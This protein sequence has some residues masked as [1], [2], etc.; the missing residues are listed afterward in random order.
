MEVSNE[1]LAYL[2]KLE[3]E[4]EI[5][6]MKEKLPHKFVPLYKWQRKFLESTNRFNFVTA[7]NQ[8]GKSS[9]S[10][11]KSITWATET[12]LWPKLWP[13]KI[14]QGR[15]ITCFF[16]LYEDLNMATREFNEKWIKEWLPRGDMKNDPKYGWKAQYLHKKIHSL[17][18]NSGVT[19]YFL[20]YSQDVMSM[21]AATVFAL[22]CDEELIFTHYP[23]LKARLSNTHG[24]FHMVFT[25]TK[26]QEEWRLT[27]EEQGTDYELFKGA[28]KD[29]ISLYEC[30]E[31]ETGKKTQWTNARIQE[32]ING[33]GTNEEV[34]KRIFGKF[35]KVTGLTFPAFDRKENVIVIS[36]QRKLP[37]DWYTYVGIDIGSGGKSGHPSAICFVKVNKGFTRGYVYKTWRG[38]GIS[39]TASDVLNQ[40]RKMAENEDITNAYYDWASAEFGLIAQRSGEP[41][42]KA[43]KTKERGVQ[44]INTLFRN[45]MLKIHEDEESRKL[46]NELCSLSV[47][48]HKTKAKDDAIDSMTYAVTSI[49]WDFSCINNAP[50]TKK[51]TTKR[52]NERDTVI[53]KQLKGMS[54]AKIQSLDEQESL[55]M[56]ELSEWDDFANEF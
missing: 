38:D 40:Y 36:T 9:I 17:E 53:S 19:I 25:A 30:Q 55:L 34:Q 52:L 27:M 54:T 45:K 5:V 7:A 26:A 20:G 2:E 16:Y 50:R 8:V 37:E 13:D 48:T 56:K 12:D 11:I 24:Y 51:K 46:I 39:T 21:Q 14:K 47:E 31:Y 15:P 28:Y 29:Q 43:D 44:L 6:K 3:R 33:Y 22:F 1:R 10:I 4:N 35:V 49:P 23:E 42:L 41:M 32:E 18:F